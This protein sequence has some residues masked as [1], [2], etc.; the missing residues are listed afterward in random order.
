[1]SSRAPRI[2]R[3]EHLNPLV[4]IGVFSALSALLWVGI[5]A[6]ARLAL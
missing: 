5:I 6:L 2:P 3:D 4:C 1:M